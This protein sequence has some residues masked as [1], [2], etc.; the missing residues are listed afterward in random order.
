MTLCTISAAESPALSSNAYDW[1]S[2][3]PWS[4]RTVTTYADIPISIG[5]WYLRDD[6]NQLQYGSDFV[7]V[8]LEKY[9]TD[10]YISPVNVRVSFV[11]YW[12]DLKHDYDSWYEFKRVTPKWRIRLTNGQGANENYDNLS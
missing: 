4:K 7:N 3:A 9:D 10:N 1:L 5:Q 12:V 11:G 8:Y 6:D 2:S